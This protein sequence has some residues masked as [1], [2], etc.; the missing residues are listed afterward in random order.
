MPG[1]VH[2]RCCGVAGV[3]TSRPQLSDT[4]CRLVCSSTVMDTTRLASTQP[5]W[6]A[7]IIFEIL[8]SS[9]ILEIIKTLEISEIL[10]IHDILEIREILVILEITENSEILEILDILKFLKF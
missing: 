5:G 3:C 10:E 7:P 1:N 2:G 6:P 4:V 9:E 8:E